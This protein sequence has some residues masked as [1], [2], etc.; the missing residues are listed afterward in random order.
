MTIELAHDQRAHARLSPSGASRW[1]PCP[2]SVA[3]EANEPDTSSDFA[4]E[5]TAAHEMAAAALLAG[6]DAADHVGTVIYV[7]GKPWTVTAEMAE[8]VQSYLDYVRA[9]GGNLMVEQRLDLLNIFPDIEK[10]LGAT[11][12]VPLW[13]LGHT[14]DGRLNHPATWDCALFWFESRILNA[15]S[16]DGRVSAGASRTM[17]KSNA[18][19]LRH[20]ATSGHI[21]T[22]SASCHQEKGSLGRSTAKPSSRSCT[23][24]GGGERR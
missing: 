18:H 8:Y 12:E 7:S 5:G 16:T 17:R 6:N 19:G 21:T 24:C 10:H 2:A 11:A 3:L 22:T 15:I 23:T 4:D 9:L 1:M 13:T 14:S 20:C